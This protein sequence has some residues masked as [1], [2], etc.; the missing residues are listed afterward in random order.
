MTSIIKIIDVKKDVDYVWEKVRNVGGVTELT[1]LITECRLDG[2]TRYCTL[3][4]GAKLVEK[5]ISID[6]AVK[7]I[8]YTITD[9]PMPLD[10]HFAS[11]QVVK[12]GSGAQMIWSVDFK[13]D[14]LAEGFAPMM[15]MIAESFKEN[16]S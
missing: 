5:I 8:G 1:N 4:D 6:E 10:F 14:A 11:L 2:D 13:P 16:L 7:R 9:G 3:A 15:D 12:N